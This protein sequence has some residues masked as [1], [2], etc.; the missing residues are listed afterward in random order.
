VNNTAIIFGASGQDGFYLTDLLKRQGYTI[1]G[2]DR[3]SDIKLDSY[4]DVEG[5]IKEI[6]PAYIF[7]LAARSATR[8]EDWF[9]NHET[10]VNG[11]H[12]ILES[13]WKYSGHTRVFISGSGLQFVNLGNPINE[14]TPFFPGSAY[15]VSRIQSVF[16]A[17]YY[18]I[19]GV[20][21]YVGYFFNHDSP[22]R[23]ES[24]INM[25]IIR[26]AQK[27]KNG[28][29]EKLVVGDPSVEKEF[30]FAGDIVAGIWALVNQDNV[31][32]AAIGTGSAK[33]ILEWI[34]KVFNIYGLPVESNLQID[35]SYVAPY[36]RLVSDPAT[37][38]A[39]GWLPSTTFDELAEMMCR[40]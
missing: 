39:L 26:T 23:S 7:H 22:R 37:M 17:R 14:S 29:L 19:L 35:P 32:E 21:V 10:V 18:R 15:A 24:H 31:F 9:L 1:I 8:H 34:N 5:L 27:I 38:F 16:T 36:K 28:S 6:K 2:I 12:F 3:T 20:R 40:V 25:R 4:P 13:V 30:G 11:T 33:S